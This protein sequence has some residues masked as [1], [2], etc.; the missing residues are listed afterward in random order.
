MASLR[1]ARTR[2]LRAR[3]LRALRLLALSLLALPPLAR[4]AAAQA[5][6]ARPVP[7]RPALRAGADTNDALLYMAAGAQRL[8]RDPKYA[9][10]AFHWAARLD[11][12]LAEAREGE[13]VAILLGDMNRL[14]RY[15]RGDRATHASPEIAYTDSLQR[16]A[17]MQNPLYVRRYD[18]VLLESYLREMVQRDGANPS[19]AAHL[20]STYLATEAPDW[21]RA[22]SALSSGRYQDAV[23]L[24]KR[25]LSRERRPSPELYAERARAFVLLGALDSAIAGF[26][27]AMN[28]EH[29]KDGE[30]LVFAYESKAQYEHVIGMVHQMRGDTAKAREAFQRALVEDLA[31]F[32]AHR[33]LAELALVAGDTATA[34]QSIDQATQIAGDDP[35]LRYSYG[36]ALVLANR[37]SDAVTHLYKATELAPEYPEPW[38]LLARIHDVGGMPD[39]AKEQYQRFLSLA[40]QRN[41]NRA[42]AETRLA[43]LAAAK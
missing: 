14:R 12:T 4:A 6:A 20:V 18:R 37:V 7:P 29:R 36:Y 19:E 16:R 23:A 28:A 27:L 22:W 9:E 30:A 35:A 42:L 1:P 24:Y 5:P 38:F 39:E 13:R 43:A 26:T 31:Y 3:T 25:A 21:M 8:D 17:L 2:T 33:Q 11:P 10:A 15:F 34:L 40:S 41:A 32:P